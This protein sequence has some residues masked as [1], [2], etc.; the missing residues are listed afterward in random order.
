MRQKSITRKNREL[1]A[2]PFRD[3]LVASVGQ[4]EHCG[5]SPSNR[6]GRMSELASLAVHEIASGTHRQKALDKPYAVLVLCW[7]CNSGPF[8]NRGEWPESRQLALLAQRRPSD[9]DLTAYLELTSPRAMRRIEID[10]VLQWM[11]G[12]YLSKQE[13]AQKL[14]VDRR[15]VQNWIDTGL[16]PAMDCRTAGASKPL[17]RVAWTDYLRFC[18]SRRV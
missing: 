6:H 15:S 8:Q 9:F 17:Y 5:C 18:Q 4:C 12:E 7:Q 14:S 16:L 1:E 10:E 2:K 13:I 11:E 3:N